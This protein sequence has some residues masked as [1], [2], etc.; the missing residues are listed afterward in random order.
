MAH[1]DIVDFL[2]AQP[3]IDAKGFD[4]TKKSVL[5]HAAKRP[6]QVEGAG[7]AQVR[8]AQ[9]LIAAGL[10]VDASDQNGY[11]NIRTMGKPTVVL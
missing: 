9:K 2:L 6:L 7:H 1:V 4:C 3:S 10:D 11:P 5:H 8:I